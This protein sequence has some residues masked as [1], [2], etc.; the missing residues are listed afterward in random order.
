MKTR[1]AT[2]LML[3]IIAGC[4]PPLTKS[5]HTETVTSA[6][7]VIAYGGRM[8]K[9]DVV[10]AARGLPLNGKVGICAAFFAYENNIFSM[11]AHRFALGNVSFFLDDEKIGVGAGFAARYLDEPRQFGQ[12]T[13]C[14]STDTPWRPELSGKP[15]KMR[16]NWAVFKA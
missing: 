15:V 3:L 13:H 7:S 16:L 9:P 4:S 5:Q 1:I 2:T 14:A 8:Q 6:Y 12:A 11:D 10:I